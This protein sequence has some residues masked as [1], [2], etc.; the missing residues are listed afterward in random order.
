MY[1]GQQYPPH[2]GGGIGGL[3]RPL[4][5]FFKNI[6]APAAKRI[7]KSDV[8]QKSLKAVK[9]AAIG[10]T[11]DAISGGVSKE[12]AKSH[13]G[14]AREEVAQALLD[15]QGEG[16]VKKKRKVRKFKPASQRGGVRKGVRGGGTPSFFI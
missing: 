12:G 5:K 11:A 1:F 16:K 3:F 7:I 14:K 6:I 13:I 8:G 10:I 9:K 2:I 15:T 4:I